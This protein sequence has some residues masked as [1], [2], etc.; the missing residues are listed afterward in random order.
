[1][2]MRKITYI[3]AIIEAQREEMRRDENVFVL[4][5]DVGLYGGVFKA[6]KGLMDEFGFYRCL[7]TPISESAIVGIAT[8]AALMGMRPI[9]EIQFADFIGGAHDQICQQ[10]AKIYYRT[11]GTWP[12]PITI[13]CPYG[14]DVGGGMYHSQS[15][16]AWYCH[17]AG[18]KVV[19][20]STPY[21][22][23]G[24]L[25]AAI[26]DNN[27]VLY[28]EHKKLYRTIKEPVPDD[29]FVVPIG[30]AEVKKPG[31]HL[32]IFSFGLMFHRSMQAALKLKEEGIDVEV[33]DLRTLLP[34]DMETI[35]ES[36]KKTGKALV[37]H[38]APKYGGIGG[39]IASAI[40]EECWD[41]LDGPVV[42]V[43]APDTPVPF[44][45][46]MEQLFLPSVE[47]IYQEAKKLF[48]Y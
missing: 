29:D 2:G 34:L 10:A 7:D 39:E 11:G 27:P 23:K 21:D 14:G 33:V 25:K 46:K 30:K 38:E 3:D 22:A 28:F 35:A 5:E 37:V 6:T 41:Y 20:P 12:V 1:M 13:R 36:V 8:G 17:V 43:A 44:H 18:L 31:R 40:V 16:E 32:S 19:V 48:E 24:L 9:A 26:R 42:R 47:R 45:P 4:G 15:N